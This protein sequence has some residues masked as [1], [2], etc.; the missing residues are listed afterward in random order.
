MAFTYTLGIRVYDFHPHFGGWSVWFSSTL[1]ALR[2]MFFT[3]TLGLRVWRSTFSG[4]GSGVDPLEKSCL[5]SG[6][7]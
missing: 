7:G 2:F 1:W 5:V 6:L 4:I 3:Y